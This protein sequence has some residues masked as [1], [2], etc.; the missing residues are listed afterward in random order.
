MYLLFVLV[1]QRRT[2]GTLRS[3]R[4]MMGVSC[5]RT[6]FPSTTVVEYLDMKE[7]VSKKKTKIVNTIR[8]AFLRK[9]YV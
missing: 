5:G 2:L 1:R 9:T 7:I 4:K 3:V 6:T 8:M